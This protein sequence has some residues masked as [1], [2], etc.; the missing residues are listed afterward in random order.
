MIG[1]TA[2]VVYIAI[3]VL[4]YS[5][6][7]SMIGGAVGRYFSHEWGGEV[8][9]GS[10][11]LDP[12]NHVSL[13]NVRLVS[14]DG[15]TVLD[16]GRIACRFTGL[17]IAN[18]GIRM[19]RVVIRNTMF[20]LTSGGGKSSFKYIAEYYKERSKKKEKVKKDG[21]PF[22]VDIRDVVLDNV[23]YR[24]TLKPIKYYSNREHGV[25]VANM[26][27]D[28][29][30]GHITNLMVVNDA[31]KCKIVKLA[32][33]ER[34]GWRM[35]KLAGDVDVSGK[36]IHVTNMTLNTCGMKM[37][38]DVHLVYDS[39]RSL[40]RYCDSVY[41]DVTF[42]KGN[43]LS[44]LDAAYWAPSLWGC[45]TPV[46]IEGRVIGP[47]NDLRVENFVIGF[48][49]VSHIEIDGTV[50]GLPFIESTF[51]DLH[52]HQLRTNIGDLMAINH[53]G[54]LDVG[55]KNV[56]ED[57]G[58]MDVAADLVGGANKCFANM[59]VRTALGNVSVT[60][61][62]VYNGAKKRTEAK[63]KLNSPM[64]ALPRVA[65]NE[66]VAR[67]G[68]D[69]D[70]EANGSDLDN[71][72][73]TIGARLND[74]WLAGNEIDRA[75]MEATIADRRCE[76]ALTVEDEVLGVEA[77][78]AV[79][80]GKEKE[81]RY[82]VD[83]DIATADLKRLKLLTADSMCEVSTHIEAD[84]SMVGGNPTG[85]ARISNTHLKKD[86]RNLDLDEVRVK[87]EEKE[88]KKKIQ[89][90]SDM[91]NVN[92][93]GY[94]DY[95]D[96]PLMVKKFEYDYV[97]EYWLEGRAKKRL[98]E[99]ESVRI[100]DATMD[101]N[102]RWK[103]RKKQVHFFVP[104]LNIAEGTTLT[105]SYNYTESMKVVLRSD[106]IGMGGITLN[107]IGLNSNSQGERYRIAADITE[108]EV[109]QKGV[110]SG[111]KANLYAGNEGGLVD[112][113]WQPSTGAIET[114]GEVAIA[115]QSDSMDN[116]LTIVKPYFTINGEQ[117]E[118]GKR[119]EVR[120]NKERIAV[121]QVELK[122]EDQSLV[123]SYFRSKSHE[124][125]IA[126][127]VFE[128]FHLATLSDVLVKE[129]GL[130]A[131][132][133][134]NG[135]ANVRWVEGN[136]APLVKANLM[137]D[138]CTLNGHRL[139]NVNMRTNFDLEK[140]RMHLFVNTDLV[141]TNTISHP[142]QASGYVDFGENTM[143]DLTAGFERFDLES[144]SPL[145]KSFSS[146][147]EGYL[148]GDLA[149]KGTLKDPKIEGKAWVQSGY[150][151]IDATNVAYLF[152][153]T[154]S[155]TNNL[156]HLNKFTIRDNDNNK[157][158]LS[159]DIHYNGFS[160]VLLDLGV[161]SERLM[162][163]GA[164]PTGSNAY[165]SLYAQLAGTVKGP[166]DKIDIKATAKTLNGSDL[167]IPV[168]S[169]K[170]VKS[171]DWIVFVSDE[172]YMKKPEEL[173]NEKKKM[174]VSS[175]IDLNLTLTPDLKLHLPA[176]MSGVSLDINGS[177]NGELQVSMAPKRDMQVVGDYVVESGNI[178]VGLLSVVTKEF[179]IEDGG[180]I[181][182]PGK[183]GEA[184]VDVNAIYSQR[185]ELSSLLGSEENEIAQKP[186]PVESIVSLSGRLMS[187]SISFD[188]RLPTADQST[189]EEVF[190]YID[191]TN[192]RDMLNQTLYLLVSGKFY[193]NNSNNT[194]SSGTDLTGSGIA[195]VANSVGSVVSSMIDFVDIDFDYSAATSTRSEQYSVGINKQWNKF[196]IESTLGYGG[197]DRD[198]S[199]DE[200]LANNIVGD[201]LLGY[202]FNPR[203]HLFVF[204][205]SNTNDYTRHELPYKQGFGLKY[206]KD[207]DKWKDLIRRKNKKKNSVQKQSE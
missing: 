153:D 14:P 113:A 119:G 35:E 62:L 127:A 95:S 56:Y 76:M 34:S 88:G 142:M 64:M 48:G 67:S 115:L 178:K 128:N 114:N 2:L 192:E 18:G 164:K 71:L 13:H 15:D 8:H 167:T 44:M 109:K 97:P 29:V 60:A 45:D 63:V 144:V 3:A 19:K 161:R 135:N 189:Q 89:M 172:D 121:D 158:Q 197:Y 126:Q 4:N 129:K 24:M 16:A 108:V 111:L 176:D 87:V 11:G 139:G 196:Y 39:W 103:D 54:E 140:R 201:M 117:W 150:I 47:V 10:V 125:D 110:V 12:L 40:D 98:S 86:E 141:E 159:G 188:L 43:Q 195:A 138:S 132:G 21:D 94:F 83:M 46:K 143:V 85:Y 17:P 191:R 101:V 120:L 70:I 160:N 105:A 65:G 190:A 37:K 154:I 116:Q 68:F 193:N 149:I 163:Y 112:V 52:L 203:L 124:N 155:L 61:N 156:I 205:R 7:Q 202:K 199:S 187:P 57:L 93:G 69:I 81:N 31:V 73:A 6:V 200:A 134:V 23:C 9:V 130:D 185:V 165:G 147:F 99:E 137:V 168:T 106:S 146:R 20:H 180:T 207:F 148:T 78:G 100:A 173:K 152:D 79:T 174:A 179:K 28:S 91:V 96:I 175:N 204:N 59:D 151:N 181:E 80:L 66:W 50:S 1:W 186:I 72:K 58:T 171:S 183:I 170:S 206:V 198:L 30:T 32:T 27:M 25:D 177:G 42:K 131:A 90:E 33:V 5:V 38:S 162:V 169:Q 49:R 36:G 74:T 102:I 26:E 133:S 122:C 118:L 104:K 136:G 123:L 53:P 107:S 75:I 182:F 55:D 157:A 166:L 194:T 41:M 184:K 82:S 22:V 51:F 92:V 145:L 84:I 77:L